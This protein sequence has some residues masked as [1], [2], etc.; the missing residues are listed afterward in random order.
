MVRTSRVGVATVMLHALL[1]ATPA[2]HRISW[3]CVLWRDFQPSCSTE[4]G[5]VPSILPAWRPLIPLLCFLSSHVCT[6]CSD[7]LLQ[8]PEAQL[9][10]FLFTLKGE[11][12]TE[13]FQRYL[14]Q[15]G[16]A[17]RPTYRRTDSMGFTCL[18]VMMLPG[19]PHR[20]DQLVMA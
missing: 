16:C 5:W 20:Q 7:V 10:P 12:G 1:L 8:L 3:K 11:A 18:T 15:E 17:V 6:C 19:E 4:G 2:S 13:T 9:C 14:S